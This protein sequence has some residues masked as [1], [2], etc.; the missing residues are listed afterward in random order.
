MYMLHD[1]MEE[2]NGELFIDGVAVADAADRFGTPLYLYSEQRMRD[3]Y[4]RI[5]SAFHSRRKNFKLNFAV[6]ANNNL[7]TLNILRSEG[8]GADCSCPAEIMLAKM[9]GFHDEQLLYS[10][11]Y[12]TDEEL[13][14][15]LESGAI[16]NLDDGPLLKRLLRFG[17]PEVISFRINP[18]RGQG[19]Y[20]GLVFAG[21]DAK[22]GMMEAEALRAYR[23][24]RDSGI[25][26]F[27][28]HMMS[29]SNVLDPEYFPAITERLMEI[30]DN[31]ASE[32][33]IGFEFIDIGGGFGVPYQED[34][35]VL[36]IEEVASAVVDS[37][38]E[39]TGGAIGDPTLFIEPGRYLVC[40]AG[41]LLAKVTHVK[42]GQKNFVGCDAGMNTLLRPALYGAYHEIIPATQ[43][44]AERQFTANVTGQICENSDIMG[45]DRKLPE[46]KEGEVLA[47]LNCGAYGY[48]MASN[49]NTRTMPAE[50]F[51]I[52]GQ[53]HLTREREAMTDFLRRQVVPAAVMR[54]TP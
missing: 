28:L 39:K 12:N 6:K 52:G 47:I 1:Y 35:R 18:G 48:S 2:R 21:P 40:D 32:L 29:G 9:A 45:K 54:D 7:T 33:K 17:K 20:E 27:G 37:F 36:P 8:S 31:I 53:L 23:F 24:A 11:N 38:E 14:Y 5:Y 41:V 3:N 44:N 25:G 50:A 13:R 46:M 34:E 16:V 49:Y 42:K 22:F 51:V 30:A 4:R 43:L 15:G 10:G 19:K 26:K